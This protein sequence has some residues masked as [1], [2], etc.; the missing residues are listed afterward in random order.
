[1]SELKLETTR[2]LKIH[3]IAGS[4]CGIFSDFLV[5]P[6]DLTQTRLQVS[7]E[8][9]APKVFPFMKDIIRKEGFISLWKGFET[10]AW[11]T[12]PGHALYFTC[13]EA[14]KKTLNHFFDIREDDNFFVH[15]MAGIGADLGG[16]IIY[17]PA[18][19]IKQNLQVQS[20]T[21]S[22]K[23]FFAPATIITAKNLVQMHGIING[24]YRG[25][26]MHLIVDVPEIALFFPLYEQLKI[27]AKK[28][29]ERPSVNDMPWWTYAACSGMTSAALSVVFNPFEVVRTRVQVRMNTG[30]Q[31]KGNL[32]AAKRIYKEE[33]AMAFFKGLKAYTMARTLGASITL[34]T[35]KNS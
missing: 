16:S 15:L 9:K 2:D 12:I 32:D 27:R 21:Q 8:V 23:Q 13:Y 7:Q 4:V 5:H 35:C 3:L 29:L 25:W 17:T 24:L 30:T 1:M 26:W 19:I 11:T 34:L 20:H 14:S 28:I 33:G 6:F 18:E 31:Y 22:T 10:V